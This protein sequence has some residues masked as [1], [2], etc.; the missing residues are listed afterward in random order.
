VHKVKNLG[1][2]YTPDNIVDD[3]LRL[4]KNNGTALEPSSGNG[5]FS[6][7]IDDI[8][9]IE[10]D[11]TNKLHNIIMDFFDYSTDNKFNTIIGNPPYVAYKHI[12]A[13]SLIKIKSLD[14][15]NEFDNRTN[16]YIYFIRKCLEH[17]SENG[18]MIFITPR[19]FI[20]ATSAIKLNNLLYK[21]GTITDWH[22][23]G[24]QPAFKGYSPTVAIWRFEK[25]NFSRITKTKIGDK[26]FNLNNGQISF[27]SH[28]YDIKFSDIF[29]VKVGAVSGC[30][31]I[32]AHKN[33]DTDFVCSYT[34]T[35]GLLKRM[36]YDKKDEYINA[37]KDVLI[38]RKIK[39]FTENNW[40][41]WG[42][43]LY[44]SNQ[45][46]I[47]VNCKTR[48]KKPFFTHECKNYDGSVLAIFPKIDMD[49]HQIVDL[50]NNVDWNDLGF[51]I[52]ERLCF[53]QKAL[54]N[55]CLIGENWLHLIKEHISSNQIGTVESKN[56][57]EFL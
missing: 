3:M 31:K 12:L 4:R 35:N 45:E 40:W 44:K 7:K 22:E 10:I 16:L 52:G 51:L 8:I 34:K 46:R 48:D 47:Y 43:G 5:A 14:Y 20:N 39:K 30:D 24:D 11:G 41:H 18:E 19:N 15:L 37:H 57:D 17:L 32:F 38:N 36:Y 33:G 1:Q 23:Y 54:E 21:L 50:L 29:F 25:N 9:S 42:R 49:I 27:T 28:D 55:S 13:D 6:S 53:S 2:V 26:K 56:N